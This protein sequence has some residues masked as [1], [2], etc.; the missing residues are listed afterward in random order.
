MRRCNRDKRSEVK[1]GTSRAA[2]SSKLRPVRSFAV[3]TGGAVAYS[4]KWPV[5]ILRM[6]KTFQSQTSPPQVYGKACKRD[7]IF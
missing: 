6:V 5:D 3:N 7:G 1:Y 4:A 2:P